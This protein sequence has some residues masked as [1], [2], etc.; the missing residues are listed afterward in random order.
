MC[1]LNNVKGMIVNMKTTI[2][3]QL[4]DVK[5]VLIV[6]DMVNG[7]VKEGALASSNIEHI[8]PEII[9]TIEFCKERGDQLIFIRDCH[10]RG[11]SE[12]KPYGPYAE[13][14]LKGTAEC[15]IIDELQPYV[16]ADVLVIDKNNTNFMFAPK[17]I[18][19]LEMMPNLEEVIGCGCL[20]EV[21]VV[22]GLIALKQWCNEYNRQVEVSTSEDIME[23]YTASDH[24]IAYWNQFAKQMMELNGVKV[25]G[26]RKEWK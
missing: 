6:I 23:T 4:Q 9:R 20:S 1:T 16:T 10:E 5:R 14:C 26:K 8:I 22:N 24:D 3:Q 18:P 11:C 19:Y 13:H 15:E 17:M 7:F 25:Y 2:K 12:C 21:C